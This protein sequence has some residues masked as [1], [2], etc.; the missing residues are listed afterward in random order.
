M[1]R[2]T[3]TLHLVLLSVFIQ[4]KYFLPGCLFAVVVIKCFMIGVNVWRVYLAPQ[5]IPRAI[6]VLT[7]GNK[8]LLYFAL[9]SSF[10]GAAMLLCS[11]QMKSRQQLACGACDTFATRD[12]LICFAPSSFYHFLSCHWWW[13]KLLG[14]KW[15]QLWLCFYDFQTP[16]FN[17]QDVF[18]PF[19]VKSK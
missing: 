13:Y 10:S 15:K 6:S 19:L 2:F 16:T 5:N 1:E 4:K 8:V 11:V 3:S 14:A 12:N 9:N 17:K 18:I 7:L